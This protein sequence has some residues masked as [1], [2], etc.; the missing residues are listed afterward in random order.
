MK[1]TDRRQSPWDGVFDTFQEAR[2]DATVFDGDIWLDKCL[3][4][5]RASLASAQTSAALSPVNETR[6]YVLAVVAGFAAARDGVLR[7]LDFGGGLGTSYIPLNQAINPD[8]VLD[9]VIVE[10]EALCRAGQRLFADD[11][12]VTFVSELPDRMQKFDIV[13]CG[14]SFHYVDDW[15]GMLSRFAAFDPEYLVFADLPAADNLTFVT[16]QH[17]HGREIPVRFWNIGEFMQAVE[18]LGY[19]SEFKARYRSGFLG[20]AA[21]P[22]TDNFDPPHRLAYFSQLV[23]RRNQRS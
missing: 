9:Y 16:K 21:L 13:H 10:T 6:D 4:R 11:K 14:S 2:G 22:P 23:F 3:A 5:A 7:I 8:K 15:R 19:K 18:D 20:E 17:F 12:Q 1:L